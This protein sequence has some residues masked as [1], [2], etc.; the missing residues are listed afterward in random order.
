MF[1]RLFQYKYL[2]AL[3]KVQDIF[4]RPDQLDKI[5]R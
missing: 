2:N 3:Q 4:Y 5:W 1:S